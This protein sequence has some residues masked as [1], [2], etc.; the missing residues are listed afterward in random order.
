MDQNGAVKI[1]YWGI[2]EGTNTIQEPIGIA[3]FRDELAQ[4]YVS[5][6]RGRPAGLGGGFYEL[7][8][9]FLAVISIH[10]V[11]KLIGDGIAFDLLKSGT[12]AFML[13][14]LLAA[15]ER[16]KKRNSKR[17]VDIH[18]VSFIF[19][20]A[21]GSVHHLLIHSAVLSSGFGQRDGNDFISA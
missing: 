2:P 14:P 20:D 11:L 6:V 8:I 17:D 3:E 18:V 12:K 19:Q 5:L 21:E 9:E 1:S 13:R 7:A 10:D 15:Y 4:S 16:L